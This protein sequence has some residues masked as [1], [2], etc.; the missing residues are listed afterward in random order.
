M[1][2][3]QRIISNTAVRTLLLCGKTKKFSLEKW[4]EV[5]DPCGGVTFTK[6]KQN[7]IR[8]FGTINILEAIKN[9]LKLWMQCGAMT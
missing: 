3:D 2:G 7:V 5:T 4:L 6:T 1:Y 9:P 8:A